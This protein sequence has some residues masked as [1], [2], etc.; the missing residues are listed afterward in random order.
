MINT[1][2]ARGR[3]ISE[4]VDIIK[5]DEHKLVIT[6]E[7]ALACS[8]QEMTLQEKRL[9]M[10]VISHVDPKDQEFI[11]YR[12]PI[13]AIK[14]YLGIKNKDIYK[15]TEELTTKLMGRVLHIEDDNG[16]WEKFQWLSYCKYLSKERDKKG[17][18][19]IQ[20]K[21]H[22]H[23][24]PMLLNLTKYFGS[25]PLFQL[26]PMPSIN[27]IR[28]FEI[29]WHTSMQLM[30]TQL[31]FCL[32][33]LKIKM[34][35]KGKYNNFNDFKKNILEK[36]KKDCEKYT[37]L[38]FTYESEKRGRKIDR[39][40]FTLASNEKLISL[41][42]ITHETSQKIAGLIPQKSPQ[43][44]N[45]PIS[46]QP[47]PPEHVDIFNLLKK[48]GVADKECQKLIDQ[49]SIE[50]I[51]RN[52]LII[53]QKYDTGKIPDGAIGSWTVKAICED[54]HTVNN[55]KSPLELETEAKQKK[56]KALREAKE[57]RF[58]KKKALEDRFNAE[59]N[60][61][62]DEMYEALKQTSILETEE[63]EFIKERIGKSGVLYNQYKKK[64]MSSKL[65]LE[66]FKSF[67]AVRYLKGEFRS[68]ENWCEINKIDVAKELA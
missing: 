61:A 41:V 21:I 20:I 37:P 17:E 13:S 63:V 34:H 50:Q 36:A 28:I 42:A 43:S 47:I 60:K 16:N 5:I 19:C 51:E 29:L 1:Y 26:A 12:I 18:A 68:F 40:N 31:S 8:V 54:W 15:R 56:A 62:V 65:I 44:I 33:D 38:I 7:N 45:K 55:Q 64:G 58:Q 30:K 11:K 4:L 27:S 32:D 67:L 9:L 23:L 2:K 53:Q 48:H 24:R 25:V 3:D 59:K 46:S 39:V 66:T 22:E 52:I 49:Y 6:Q 14:N 10:L 57:V 35:L